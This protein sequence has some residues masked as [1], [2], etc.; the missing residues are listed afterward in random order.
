[1]SPSKSR[2]H[3]PEQVLYFPDSGDSYLKLAARYPGFLEKYPPDAGW[4]IEITPRDF[5][6]IT[7]SRHQ[8]FVEWVKIHPDGTPSEFLA[9]KF[10]GALTVVFEGKLVSP[11]GKVVAT[12]SSFGVISEYKAWE[13][14]E[15]ACRQ[16]ILQ[17]IGLG[18]E[19]YLDEEPTQAEID[20]DA[21]AG[22]R[23]VPSVTPTPKPE[24]VKATTA[25]SEAMQKVGTKVSPQ[26]A[27]QSIANQIRSIRHSRGIADAPVPEN[28]DEAKK[29]LKGLM[30]T[31][32]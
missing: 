8:A 18:S 32:A 23:T 21:K 7:A 10:G 20:A 26:I 24:Q 30:R 9:H 4:S 17:A 22:A 31:N 5:A 1:M 14:A 3:K 19:D 15:T 2:Q 27:W 11:E 29:M 16:R 13:R 25:V 28:L 6:G 12:A